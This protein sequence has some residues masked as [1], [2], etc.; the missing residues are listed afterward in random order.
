MTEEQKQRNFRFLSV[1]EKK[2]YN[3]YKISKQVEGITQAKL[4]HLKTNRNSVSNKMINSLISFFPDVNKTWLLTGEGEMLKGAKVLSDPAEGYKKELQTAIAYYFPN[5]DASAGLSFGTNN[6]EYEKIPIQIPFWGKGLY[7]I[8]VFGD[9]MYPK[10]QSGQIIGI[11]LVEY[12]YLNFGY[13]FVV[14]FKNGDTYLK[15]VRKGKDENHVILD[16]ENKSYEAR[17]F[18]VD[19]IQAFYIVKGVISRLAM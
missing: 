9:S 10:F 6:E 7:F 16:N 18:H 13:T 12:K 1:I 11:K 17:E 8:N 3:G 14:V 2:G 5:L 19:Q 15:Y 4:T